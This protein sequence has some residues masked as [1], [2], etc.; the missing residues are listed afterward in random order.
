MVFFCELIALRMAVCSAWNTEVKGGRERRSENQREG[1]QIAAPTPRWLLDLSENFCCMNWV[2]TIWWAQVIESGNLWK[3]ILWNMLKNGRWETWYVGSLGMNFPNFEMSLNLLHSRGS[4]DGVNF[5]W[6]SI[7]WMLLGR[8][9]C[10]R[11]LVLTRNL[12]VRY[13]LR[14][15]RGNTNFRAECRDWCRS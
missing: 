3:G 7:V 13:C 10:V 1:I 12:S 6:A 2:K 4:L 5:Y 9:E 11:V 14:K 8:R 15:W